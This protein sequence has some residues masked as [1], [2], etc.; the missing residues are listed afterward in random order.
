MP[1][2]KNTSKPKDLVSGDQHLPHADAGA[3]GEES[4]ATMRN[5]SKDSSNFSVP[6]QY[7]SPDRDRPMLRVEAEVNGGR[8]AGW[9][10]PQ[11]YSADMLLSDE[12]EARQDRAGTRGRAAEM[13]AGDALGFRADKTAST[14]CLV[15][16]PVVRRQTI[17]KHPGTK[18]V[19]VELR[20]DGRVR[21]EQTRQMV[22]KGAAASGSSSLMVVGRGERV[23]GGRNSSPT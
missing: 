16:S 7:S 6:Q 13:G 18:N 8:D 23:G 15:G 12:D 10:D 17:G 3:L 21:P 2:T 11:M 4:T 1:R 5:P 20:E 14:H 22:G 9:H 19:E